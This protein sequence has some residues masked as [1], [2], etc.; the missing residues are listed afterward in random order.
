MKF[1]YELATTALAGFTGLYAG[2][3]LLGYNSAPL[4]LA[5]GAAAIGAFVVNNVFSD[6][7]DKK[8]EEVLKYRG[9]YV[10]NGDGSKVYAKKIRKEKTNYGYELEYKLPPGASEE[11]LYKLHRAMEVALNAEIEF[12]EKDGNIIFRIYT[13]TL[14]EFVDYD[15][16]DPPEDMILPV[17]VGVSRAGIEW[18]DLASAPHG[19]NSGETGGGKTNLFRVFAHE[20]M[21]S[22]NLE[23]LYVI[24]ITRKLSYLRHNAY[25]GG[26]HATIKAIVTKL[27]GI[28]EKRYAE[29]EEKGID[30]IEYAPEYKRI[31]L[32]VDEFNTLSPAMAKGD[33]VAR[34]ERY[35]ILNK[36]TELVTRGRGCGIHVILGIQRPDAKIMEDGQIKACM[37]VRFSFKTVDFSNSRIILDSPHAALLPGDVKG[38]CYMRGKDRLRQIQIFNLPLLPLAKFILPTPQKSYK[39]EVENPLK[40]LLE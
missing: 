25:F 3:Q 12:W 13:H 23:D 8:L 20:L 24:D 21:R 16:L 27:T 11:E 32:L 35:Y 10:K 7:V 38:R 33:E 26:D 4:Y 40:F 37:P 31:V 28:M 22:P 39:V 29:F 6:S 5:T 1:N 36:I 17:A 9:L 34:A 30:D 14:P 18:V 19:L 2:S 15:L